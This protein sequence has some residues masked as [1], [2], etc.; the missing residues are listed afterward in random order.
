MSASVL[1]NGML[2]LT[3]VGDTWPDKIKL[4]GGIFCYTT[5]NSGTFELTNADGVVV[6][7]SGPVEANSISSEDLVGWIDGI[8]VTSIPAGGVI[9]LQHD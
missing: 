5:T 3:A 1:G 7:R 2:A 9:L 4:C 8:V 6:Y